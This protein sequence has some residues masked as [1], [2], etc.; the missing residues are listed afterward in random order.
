MRVDP[1]LAAKAG[2]FAEFTEDP[3]LSVAA[4]LLIVVSVA[5]IVVARMISHNLRRAAALKARR[6]GRRT[7]PP[8]RMWNE[9]PP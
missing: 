6:T 2:R 7:A 8:R 9:P 5:W 1:L 4:F 3:I